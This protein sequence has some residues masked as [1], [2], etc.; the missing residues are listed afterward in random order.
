MRFFPIQF[1]RGMDIGSEAEAI[2][3]GAPHALFTS[4]WPLYLFTVHPSTATLFTHYAT[5]SGDEHS[6][7]IKFAAK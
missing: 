7:K 6:I 5:L 2:T 4:S 3:L 1:F